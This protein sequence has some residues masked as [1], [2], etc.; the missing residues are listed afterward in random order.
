MKS[1]KKTGHMGNPQL[2]EDL[3]KKLPHSLRFQW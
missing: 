3:V 1:L 2:L